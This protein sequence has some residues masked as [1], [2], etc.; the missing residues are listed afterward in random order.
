MEISK[1]IILALIAFAITAC[2]QKEYTCQD[3]EAQV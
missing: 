1:I 3:Y 2:S